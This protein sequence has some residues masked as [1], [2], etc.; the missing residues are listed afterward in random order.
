MIKLN[1]D[2]QENI[3]AYDF[4]KFYLKNSRFLGLVWVFLT[5]CAAI[6]LCIAFVSPEWIGDTLESSNRGYFGLYRYCTRTSL[7]SSYRCIGTWTDFTTLPNTP[8][9]RAACFFVGFSCILLI[10]VVLM[11]LLCF[12][13]KHERI[14]HICAWT[15]LTCCKF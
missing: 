8:A 12:I 9:L 10:L 4:Y 13:I 11:S 6:C 5:I 1:I 14:F 3:S 15:Q 7:G 2:D